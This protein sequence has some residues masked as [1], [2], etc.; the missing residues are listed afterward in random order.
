MQ[1]LV[2]SQRAAGHEVKIVYGYGRRGR[3]SPQAKSDRDAIQLCHFPRAI[4]NFWEHK[5][6]V[7]GGHIGSRA[8]SVLADACAWADVV[9]LHVIH[10]FMGGDLDLLKII[11]TSSKA[12]VWTI[13]D[14]WVL[15]GRCAITGDCDGWLEGC[16]PCKSLQHYPR[17]NIDNAGKYRSRKVELINEAASKLVL[18]PLLPWM[19]AR[20][21]R[22]FPTLRQT[23]IMNGAKATSFAPR[24][25]PNGGRHQLL[26]SAVMLT[27]E[28]KI[29]PG[30]IQAILDRTKLS[31]VTI[32]KNPPV[33][34]E[35]VTNHGF[36]PKGEKFAR[37]LAS[38][39]CY[40]F[41]SIIDMCPL[42]VIEALV[43][44][45][46]VIALSSKATDELLPLVGG[47]T[48]KNLS[49]M[50]TILQEE[51]WWQLYEPK[52]SV[53]LAARAA[54]PFSVEAMRRK[55]LETYADATS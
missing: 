17:S 12:V 37:I 50:I 47:R 29:P 10:S 6:G 25:R 55:Y 54:G 52:D 44:G 38:A 34:H 5:L 16:A 53:A 20:L 39:S 9:H 42:S 1:I 43:A 33:E 11:L 8:S 32:G 27:D 49:E 15:T 24:D 40:A 41:F 2:E 26:I 30:C 51:A 23:L 14:S 21:D 4:L 18:V 48:V 13:H 22:A 3:A 7:Y 46:P 36:L 31:I 35:R 28:Q 19:K 45:V